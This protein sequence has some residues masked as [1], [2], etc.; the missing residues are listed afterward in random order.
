MYTG[1]RLGLALQE[2]MAKKGVTQDVVAKEFS[3]SQPSVSEWRRLGRISKKHIPRLVS[4]F[5]DVVGPEHWGLPAA[6]ADNASGIDPADFQSVRRVD[7]AFSNGHGQIVYQEDD[8]PPLVFRSDFLRRLG[9]PQGQALVVDADGVSNEPKIPD[10]SV[11]LVNK[12][13]RERLNGDFFAFRVD[14]ELLIKRLDVLQD[15]GILATAENPNFRPKTKVYTRADDFEVIGRA[16][17]FGSL[18]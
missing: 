4:W 12:S 14:G 2:A 8:K 11:V 7:V 3:V 15:I 1:E 10:G 9:I 13:D 6:W 17:W 5:S 18:L 16:V